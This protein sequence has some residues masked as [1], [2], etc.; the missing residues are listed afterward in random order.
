MAGTRE[1]RLLR[2]IRAGLA[3]EDP[4]GLR[5]RA[6]ALPAMLLRHGP[7]QTLLFLHGKGDED[8]RL[9]KLLHAAVQGEDPGAPEPAEPLAAWGRLD[10]ARR[11]RLH[12][13]TVEA[14][15][16]LARDLR[17]A[18]PHPAPN[19]NPKGGG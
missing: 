5:G 16:L 19:P 4:A 6:E 11:L 18:E 7:A 14:A 13:L 3:Q 1:Q 2:A 8:R 10:P 12:A 15:A 17:A 9:A